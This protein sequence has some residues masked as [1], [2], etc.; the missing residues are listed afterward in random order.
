MRERLTCSLIPSLSSGRSP[1]PNPNP[2]PNPNPELKVPSRGRPSAWPSGKTPPGG[3]SS[4]SPSQ[5]SWASQTLPLGTGIPDVSVEALGSLSPTYGGSLSPS[6]KTDRYGKSPKRAP[7]IPVHSPR[8]RF[9][10]VEK[11]HKPIGK[12]IGF[13]SPALIRR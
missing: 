3:V 11:T 13:G 8:E 4:L 10:I 12:R 5:P 1:H 6:P 9:N 2:N 7:R